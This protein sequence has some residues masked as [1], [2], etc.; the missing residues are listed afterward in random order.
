MSN[1]TQA[2]QIQ[3]WAG[4]AADGT[5]EQ[6]VTL[7][8]F[9]DAKFARPSTG[10]LYGF[11]LVGTVDN[12]TLQAGELDTTPLAYIDNT[13]DKAVNGGAVVANVG[14]VGSNSLNTNLL[15]GAVANLVSI[16]DSEDDDYLDE[17][18]KKIYGLLQ[19]T[20]VDGGAMSA[21]SVQLS[22][23]IRNDTTNAF[24]A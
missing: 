6:Y 18:G 12:Y 1:T 17:T 9:L 3:G 4:F 13:S 19:T 11:S 22:F 24:E 20:A 10:S 2:N 15:G 21:G 14:S 7:Q 16:L 23:V 8:E 5:T